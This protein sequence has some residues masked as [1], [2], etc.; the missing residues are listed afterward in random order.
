MSDTVPV[1]GW[2]N[3]VCRSPLLFRAVM[4]VWRRSWID[5]SHSWCSHNNITVRD[6]HTTLGLV[7]GDLSRLISCIDRVASGTKC[8]VMRLVIRCGVRIFVLG[9]RSLLLDVTTGATPGPIG[10]Y[11]I[12]EGRLDLCWRRLG[13]RKYC[14]VNAP[15]TSQWKNTE[16]HFT[17]L[18]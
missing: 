15:A 2:I 3:Q 13:P 4:V 9:C 5:S 16:Y 12:E 17:L 11:A 18:L 14:V 6:W 1:C 7:P 8:N 10:K